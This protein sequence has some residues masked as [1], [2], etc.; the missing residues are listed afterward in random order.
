MPGPAAGMCEPRFMAVREAFE[1]GFRRHGELGAAVCVVSDGCPVVDLWGGFQDEART[2]PWERD[3]LVNVFSVTKGLVAACLA[4]L[5]DR[6]RLDVDAPV[7]EYWPEF[8]ASDKQHITVSEMLAHQ[9]GLPALRARL[10]VD[11]HVD[12]RSMTEAL[13][14]ER[15]W[16]P[17]G[18]ALGY[19]AITWGWLAGE[20]LRRVD[21]RSIGTF[22]R[23]E[24]AAPLGLDL[25]LGT[26]PEL[27][28]RTAPIAAG[29]MGIALSVLLYWLRTPGRMPMRLRLLTN[30]PQRDA[31]LDTRAW[32]AAE[33]PAI[34]G[35]ANARA[36]AK[37]Y[38]VLA[39]GGESGSSFL[40]RPAAL[41]RATRTQSEGR[42]LVFGIRSRFG[43]GFMLDSK[44][45][46]IATGARSFGH[47][48]SGGAF[49]FA[50]PERR[51]AFAYTPNRPHPQPRLLA[52]PARALVRAIYAS[53]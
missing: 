45:L 51:L 37:F 16:W 52:A 41:A 3:T 9:A 22:L 32:R 19:H 27:D 34:N 14:A 8:A 17:P 28:A 48:G 2:T 7:A 47:T 1:A 15:P 26:P 44:H 36:L 49:A 23:E 25:H 10:P 21:G 42:D 50:D 24:V 18:S 29:S 39:C 20:L 40:L 43:L 46:D 38:G 5:A 53:L 6:G 35:I 11:A 33:M 13:A 4:M 30:P 31:K 12:W